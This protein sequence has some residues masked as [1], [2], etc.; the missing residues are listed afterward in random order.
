MVGVCTNMKISKSSYKP[1]MGI[2]KDKQNARTRCEPFLHLTWQ[3]TSNYQETSMRCHLM[4]LIHSVG[5][6]YIIFIPRPTESYGMSVS[7]LLQHDKFANTPMYLYHGIQYITWALLQVRVLWFVGHNCKV[8][9]MV[10]LTSFFWNTGVN[11]LVTHHNNYTN[12]FQHQ[13]KFHTN[14]YLSNY[15]TTLIM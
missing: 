10:V 15:H 14:S 11:P 12:I 5:P 3:M 2:H 4:L 1:S 6:K 8:D 9:P 7:K 13:S